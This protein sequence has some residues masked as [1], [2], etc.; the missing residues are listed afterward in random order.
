MSATRISPLAPEDARLFSA[1]RLRA[2]RMQPYLATAVFSLIPVAS[3]GLGTFAVDRFW[4][5]YVDMAC[6]HEWGV[7]ATAG[8][9]LHEAHHVVRNHHCRAATLGVDD[10]SHAL[11]NLAGDAA[12]NDDLIVDGVPIPGGVLPRHLGLRSG[13]IEEGYYRELLDAAGGRSHRTCGTGAGGVA[14]PGEVA[15][16]P[17]ESGADG[18]DHIDA[19]GI[20]RAVAH[21]VASTSDR[22]ER[23]SPGLVVWARDLLE[24]RV[25]WRQLLRSALGREVRAVTTRSR[26]DWARLDRRSEARPEFPRPGHRHEHAEIVV[27]VDT[28]ASMERPLLDAAV[29]EINGMLRRTGV[30]SLTVVVCDVDAARP[31]RVRRL[32]DLALRGGGG[33]DMRVGIA[34]AGARRPCPDVIVVLT[35]G[36]T[37]WPSQS[38]PGTVLIAVVFDHHVALPSGRGIV[39]VR[40][41]E[42]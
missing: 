29:T 31:Q 10:R 20:R 42:S 13:G 35:D 6:A 38:P 12:I 40:V 32:G 23:V 5:V 7:E 33:T 25:P 15:D 21:D 36:Y 19:T 24:P 16:E 9:L 2:A 8:V 30:S 37:P 28:S 4:R 1:A 18:I 3:P 26:P 34:A 22:G 39:A 17:V 14:A 41:S 11:W 27:V